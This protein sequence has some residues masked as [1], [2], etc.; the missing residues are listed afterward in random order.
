MKDWILM[1]FGYFFSEW[2][3]LL[4]GGTVVVSVVMFLMGV[5]K[6]L[7]INRIKYPLLR[8]VILAWLSIVVVLP[9]TYVSV[10]YNG[11]NQEYFWLIY[12]VNCVATIVIYWFYENTAFRDAL[13]LLGKNTL[14]R[15]I[16]KSQSKA[17]IE[18][19]LKDANAEA[20]K[21]LKTESKKYKED[22]INNV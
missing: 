4:M 3:S 18:S 19:A 11:F 12:G 13:A 17:D 2:W 22:D 5:L 20:S 8:K 15:I 21:L 10:L 6:K 14:G 16:G 9:V 7:L 1:A